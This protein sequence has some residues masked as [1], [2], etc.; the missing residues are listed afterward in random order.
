M[1]VITILDC[2]VFDI[3]ETYQ[4]VRLKYK[5]REVYISRVDESSVHPIIAF[6]INDEDGKTFSNVQQ[7]IDYVVHQLFDVRAVAFGIVSEP[8]KPECM[9]ERLK[10]WLDPSTN[11]GWKKQVINGV[12][13]SSK[14][15]TNRIIYLKQNGRIKSRQR[16]T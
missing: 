10:G 3:S 2:V 14:V 15:T 8:E 4:T 5:D 12:E 1:V 16:Q 6:E 11:S 7:A 9:I 13:Q